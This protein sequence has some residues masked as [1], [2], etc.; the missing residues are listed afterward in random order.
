MGLLFY[1]I[2][3]LT[4]KDMAEV[5]NAFSAFLLL[6]IP[7]HRILAKWGLLLCKGESGWGMFQEAGYSSLWILMGCTQEC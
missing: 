6:G 3:D 4:T 5:L 2:E 7:C 1:G